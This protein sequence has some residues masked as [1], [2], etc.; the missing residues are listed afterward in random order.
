MGSRVTWLAALLACIGG[1]AWADPIC[2]DRPGKG[3]GTCTVPAGVIQVETGLLDWTDD[4]ADDVT[5]IGSTLIKYGVSDRA[6]VELGVTPLITSH[7]ESGFGDILLRVKYRLTAEGSAVQVAIDPFLKLPTANSQFGNRKVEGGIVAAVSA[8]VGKSPLSL[9]LAP[10]VDW[11]ADGDGEGYH[12][13]MSQ[14]VGLGIGATSRFAFGAEL[15][16]HWDW[17]PAGTV[18][19]A[20]ADGWLTYLASNDVQ[21]DGGANFGLNAATPD[22]ELY[23][24]VAVRF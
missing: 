13:A 2:P 12:A 16:G 7:G 11:V 21:L 15:W 24:G 9:S 22:V 18:S 6:D 14:V 8:P 23:A 17:D 1:T 4:G 20:S 3:T 19:Q 5:V 10:E